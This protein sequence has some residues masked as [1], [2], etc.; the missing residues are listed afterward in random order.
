MSK[1]N[2]T[3]KRIISAA[4]QQIAGEDFYHR[5]R[6]ER[7]AEKAGV[8]EATIH[9]HFGTKGVFSKAVWQSIVEE[10]KPYSLV[11]FYNEHK[12]L[13]KDR[14]GQREFLRLMLNN[15][16]AFFRLGKSKSFRRMLR[17]FFLE[18]IGFDN[19]LR[20]HVN[21]Y[22]M[23]ELESF[24]QICKT[25]TGIDDLYHSSMLFLF[26]LQPI[27]YAY[28]HLAATRSLEK[29]TT[30]PFSHHEQLILFHAEKILLFQLG[31]LD[32]CSASEA[33]L[34]EFMF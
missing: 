20:E 6:L 29:R 4:V 13:L 15:Y 5:L 24:H 17:L 26:A 10:R 2:M 25:I 28:T 31:L 8:S 14:D 23:E 22:F 18:N 12:E 3:R 9:Y 30:V 7:I 19:G 16:Y 1:A 21:Q 33:R 11:N 27:A 32:D 34:K